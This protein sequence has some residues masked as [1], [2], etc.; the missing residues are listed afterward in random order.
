MV[1]GSYIS[2]AITTPNFSKYGKNPKFIAIICFCA[3]LIGNGLM[4]IF[5]ASSNILVGGSDIFN[6]FT[7][8][9]F[10]IIGIIVLGLNIWSSCDNGL[11]SAGLEFENIFKINHKK[12]ILFTGFASTIFS[13]YLYNS[14]VDFLSIMNYAL[15]PIGVILI[16]NYI[17]NKDYSNK[18]INVINCI[19]VIAG[20][21]LSYFLKFGISSINAI[22]V[23][24]LITIGGNCI[25]NK[26]INKGGNNS[27]ENK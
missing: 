7:Y 26:I 12:I 11:Y 18:S 6:I 9:G 27:Y 23:T 3:F 21:I 25:N 4:I 20:G 19:A 10:E 5:G 1:I 2:G 17:T 8:F 14:F 22:V 13:Y 24:A 16:I 15:P